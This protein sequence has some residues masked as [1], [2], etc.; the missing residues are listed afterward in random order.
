L[1]AGTVFA[2]T[3]KELQAKL[4]AMQSHYQ[5]LQQEQRAVNAEMNLMQ[6]QAM[7]LVAQIKE[8]K[9]KEEKDAKKKK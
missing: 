2:E 1:L 6:N 7:A 4:D 8:E 3:S 9:E 5:V